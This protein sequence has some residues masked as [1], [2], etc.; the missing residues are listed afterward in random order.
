M[1]RK[2]NMVKLTC[3]ACGT[4]GSFHAASPAA[5]VLTA[6]ESAGKEGWSYQI[7]FFTMLTG[8]HY[9]RCPTCTKSKIP[10]KEE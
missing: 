6:C 10:P 3:C 5:P 8:E 9:P 2:Q 4:T 1:K 7:G